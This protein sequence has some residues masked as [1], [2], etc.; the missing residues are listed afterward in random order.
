MRSSTLLLFSVIL[1]GKPLGSDSCS[2][3]LLVT[4]HYLIVVKAD[5]LE[6]WDALLSL[7]ELGTV[8]AQIWVLDL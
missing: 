6:L 2:H 7:N 4:L 8:L 1:G 3:L 5:F